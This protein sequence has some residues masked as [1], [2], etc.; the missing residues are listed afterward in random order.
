MQGATTAS[1]ILMANVLI[2]GAV[3]LIPLPPTGAPPSPLTHLA[4]MISDDFDDNVRDVSLWWAGQSGG[5][6]IQETN[7]RLEIIHSAEAGGQSFGAEFSSVC[8]LRGDFDIQVEFELIAWPFSNGVR[9]GLGSSA[10]GPE[11]TSFGPD[12]QDFPGEPREVYL[13]NFGTVEGITG[14]THLSGM[15]RQ[16]RT[17]NDITGFYREG[18]MWVPI[19]TAWASTVD[20]PFVLASWSHDYAF[21]D[22]E[23]K[24]AFDNFVAWAEEIV[25]PGKCTN[26]APT[27][28]AFTATEATEGTAVV[29]TAIATDPDGDA[30]TYS[31]D[32][33]A[34]G[35]FEIVDSASNTASFTWGDD[36]SGTATV[37]VSDGSAA[38]DATASVLVTNVAP[39]VTDVAASWE[40]T[41]T[42]RVA[43][44]KW[45]D[46]VLTV[47]DGS[48]PVGTASVTRLPGSPDEQA[49]TLDGFAINMLGDAVSTVVEYTPLDD[50][51]NG[52]VWGASPA[53]LVLTAEDGSEVRLHHTFNV[54]HPASW[55]WTVPDLR[56]ALVGAELGLWAT[57]TD[58]GSDDVTFTWSWG[59]GSQDDVT[60]YFNDGLGPDPYPS[61][62]VNPM[63]ATDV[64]RHSFPAAGTYDVVLSVTD[65][66]G[67][68]TEV[69][70]Q[71]VLPQ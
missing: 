9:V 14:T 70:L 51:V 3:V 17:G 36:Y 71:I 48:G 20:S 46:V 28:S 61:P 22:Q 24:L 53:W 45:H 60:T 2:L 30:L 19:H 4:D 38:S 42:L 26:A 32:F 55:V 54:Q 35:I 44:E 11:R 67:G 66:D 62:D 52:Q 56:V 8:K 13:T 1:A 65:D 43:G 23:V 50:P 5:S 18:G 69:V 40:G 37:R 31:Y 27:I 41:L 47:Y 12:D 6:T 64:A 16:V 63:T 21:G 49:V 34:D 68:V 15:L 29:F 25:G 58:P 10:G 33:D 39:S 59:D 7:Q 57:A